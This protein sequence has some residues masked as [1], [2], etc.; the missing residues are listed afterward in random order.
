MMVLPI[1]LAYL[2][3]VQLKEIMKTDG[4][5][6]KFGPKIFDQDMLYKTQLWQAIPMIDMIPLEHVQGLVAGVKLGV[7]DEKRNKTMKV[8]VNNM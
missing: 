5:I 6:R 4:T 2:L 7:D 3:P 1:Q 8:Y